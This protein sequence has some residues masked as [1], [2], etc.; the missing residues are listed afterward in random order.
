LK[1][2]LFHKLLEIFQ[3]NKIPISEDK[4]TNIFGILDSNLNTNNKIKDNKLEKEFSE[5]LLSIGNL[6]SRQYVKRDNNSFD[7][8]GSDFSNKKRPIFE[9]NSSLP[10]NK[11]E[12]FDFFKKDKEPNFT[13]NIDEADGILNNL[14]YQQIKNDDKL[15]LNE[16]IKSKHYLIKQFTFD[17]FVLRN[18]HHNNHEDHSHSHISNQEMF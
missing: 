13:I 11:K 1:K 5:A 2:K 3:K 12:S 14:D 4:M 15:H 16:P 10:K 18:N 7:D 9:I 8:S 6:S 17:D